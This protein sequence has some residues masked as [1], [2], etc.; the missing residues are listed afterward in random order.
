[1]MSGGVIGGYRRRRVVIVG[2]NEAKERQAAYIAHRQIALAQQ[3]CGSGTLSKQ[4]L[5]VVVLYVKT[6]MCGGVARL[7]IGTGRGWGSEPANQTALHPGPPRDGRHLD[8]PAVVSADSLLLSVQTRTISQLIMP[9][10]IIA[11]VKLG[12]LTVWL[13]SLAACPCIAFRL[14]LCRIRCGWRRVSSYTPVVAV[15][16]NQWDAPFAIDT[17]EYAYFRPRC[18]YST[19]TTNRA[20]THVKKLGWRCVPQQHDPRP[21]RLPAANPICR[22]EEKNSNYI[23]ARSCDRCCLTGRQAHAT[24]YH[25]H[26]YLPTA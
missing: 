9:A 23:S 21:I 19:N 22:P 8:V 12:I 16:C 25:H 26:R 3:W 15:P 6:A 5:R 4:Q 10:K 2:I 24:I 1:M 13:S 20:T 11:T 14:A 17:P 7:G 18:P